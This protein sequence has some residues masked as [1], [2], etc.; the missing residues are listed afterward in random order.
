MKSS[1]HEEAQ[2]VLDN[3]K[4]IVIDVDEEKRLLEGVV[5]RFAASGEGTACVVVG[6]PCSGRTT[7]VE[8]VVEEFQLD[9]KLQVISVAQLGSDRNALQLLTTGADM[10][11]CVLVVEDADELA[12]RQ[13]QSLL[14]LLLDMTRKNS[15]R[16]WLV[17]LMVQH[18]NF[19][20]S[21]EKRVRSRLSTARIL[22]HPALKIE[23]YIA[24]FEMFLG[25]ATEHCSKE[26]E[27]FVATFI[28]EPSVRAELEYAYSANGSYTLLKQLT[29]A[30]LC[31]YLDNVEGASA[32]ELFAEAVE[33]VMPSKHEAESKV[34][35]LSMWSLCVLL[36]V[37]RRLRSC[38]QSATVG[39]RKILQDFRRIG[40]T[41]DSRVR[42][43]SDLAVYKELDRLVELGLLEADTK[44]NNMVFR[45]CSLNMN[46]QN[47]G[48]ILREI[49][50]PAAIEYWFETQAAE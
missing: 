1:L 37:Y 49:T 24:A 31:L 44:A 17:F 2:H 46:T 38:P 50:L 3:M 41:V 34:K 18:Q 22:F 8:G 30:F 21:L 47:L 5:S 12:T 7:T 43:P 28:S 13:R 14:Y 10:K 20:T 29:T 27:T 35:S 33:M 19:M 39:Y 48:K 32:A 16:Q 9:A 4:W 40:N 25:K 45:R 42:V 36:C 23:D 6:E 11:R 15:D 26:W